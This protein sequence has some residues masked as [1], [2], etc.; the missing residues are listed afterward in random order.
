MV[1]AG[2]IARGHDVIVLTSRYGVEDETNADV[3]LHTILVHVGSPPIGSFDFPWLRAHHLFRAEAANHRALR[4]SVDEFAPDIIHIWNMGGI[5]KDLITTAGTL[6]PVVCDISDHWPIRGLPS[7]PPVRGMIAT[8]LLAR[9]LGHER[10][11]MPG[12]PQPHQL[13]NP[14]FTSKALRDMHVQAGLPVANAPIYCVTSMCRAMPV[15]PSAVLTPMEKPCVAVSWAV[16]APT[17]RRT[18]CLRQ[19]GCRW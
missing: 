13:I 5:G 17:R 18:S 9:F 19:R 6:A 1:A 14:Y 16:C 10:A 4:R 3:S 11:G 7:D 12:H 15:M 8:A 2:L